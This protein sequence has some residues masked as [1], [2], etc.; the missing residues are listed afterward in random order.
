M[1]TGQRMVWKQLSL[2]KAWYTK[3][4]ADVQMLQ[5]CKYL[6]AGSFIRLSTEGFN[7]HNCTFSNLYIILW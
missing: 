6:L 3:Q 2:K 5:I 1:T 4:F 7:L